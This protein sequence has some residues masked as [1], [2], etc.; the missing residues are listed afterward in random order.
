MKIG[1]AALTDT[2]RLVLASGKALAAE[3]GLTQFA[4]I[5]PVND[6]EFIEGQTVLIASPYGTKVGT[7]KV[8]VGENARTRYTEYSLNG[9]ILF[10]K[11]QRLR[12]GEW[13]SL[14]GPELNIPVNSTLYV[15]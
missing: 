14:F 15:S 6:I 4:Y 2:Q 13:L 9:E 8:E 7:I 5:Q 10:Q 12:D 1:I 11:S 3:L